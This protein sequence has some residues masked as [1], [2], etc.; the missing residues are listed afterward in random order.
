MAD[1]EEEEENEGSELD[2]KVKAIIVGGVVGAL[3]GIG[4]AYL[5]VRNIEEAGEDPRLAT[6]DAMSIGV[7]LVSLVRQIAN[8]GNK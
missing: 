2:W 7:S 1:D 4:A 8:M 3:I 5:Y 6:K